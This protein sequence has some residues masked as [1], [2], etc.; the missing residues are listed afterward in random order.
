M[1]LPELIAYLDAA[2]YLLCQLDSESG[3]GKAM[4]EAA[5][6]L[7]EMDEELDLLRARAPRAYILT[8]ATEWR[9]MF[10]EAIGFLHTCRRQHHG[11]DLSGRRHLIDALEQAM[12]EL[13]EPESE[14]RTRAIAELNAD[15]A[16]RL[17]AA[18]AQQD[19]TGEKNDG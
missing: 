11:T 9:R 3:E 13:G 19:H 2:A 10:G 16:N 1:K 8:R 7:E 12:K 17:K 5:M 4:R 6:R 15:E 18:H 14:R